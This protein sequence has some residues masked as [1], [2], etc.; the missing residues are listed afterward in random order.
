[1]VRYIQ[2][3]PWAEDWSGMDYRLIVAA[4]WE[5]FFG[6]LG[7]ITG[8]FVLAFDT[9]EPVLGGVFLFFQ[10]VFG[11]YVFAV[12]TIEYPLHKY[13]YD[14]SPP[15][16][17]EDSFS[18]NQLYTAVSFGSILGSVSICGILFGFQTVCTISL[19]LLQVEGSSL[20]PSLL[21]TFSFWNIFVVA[22]LGIS[23]LVIGSMIS[24]Q[25]GESEVD[26]VYIFP[27][28]YV[29]SASQTLTSGSFLVIYAFTLIFGTLGIDPHLS[30][31]HGSKK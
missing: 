5:V 16:Y 25:E 27:P 2:S 18:C 30:A 22:W 17:P 14:L 29:K 11:V 21:F 19:L 1:M 24:D 26:E 12:Y 23:M 15:T 7:M 8:L 9:T 20:Q 10:I 4:T 31:C 3:E 28:N 6:C 13:D